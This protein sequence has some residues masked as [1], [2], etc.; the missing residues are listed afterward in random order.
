MSDHS[1][2]VLHL[3]EHEFRPKS[4]NW[5]E[6]YGECGCGHNQPQDGDWKPYDVG[7]WATHV[8]DTM[9]ERGLV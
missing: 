4:T 7:N 8:A 2:L 3:V 1:I 6:P 9:I 5:Y